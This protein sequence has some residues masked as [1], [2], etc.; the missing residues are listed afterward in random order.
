[1]RTGSDTAARSVDASGPRRRGRPWVALLTALCAAVV[2]AGLVALLGRPTA[3]PLP[4]VPDAG[5]WFSDATLA[6]IAAYRRPLFFVVPVAVV[7]GAVGPLVVVTRPRVRAWL[8]GRGGSPGP[9]AG[10]GRVAL[11]AGAV[12]V[13]VVVVQD[14]L[15]LPWRWWIGYVH[16]GAHGLRTQ[17]LAGWSVDRFVTD[18]T[19]AVGVAVVVALVAALVVW[20]PR[21]WPPVLALAL[22]VLI[23]VVVVGWPLVV[24]PLRFRFQPLPDGPT[25][26]EVVDVAAQAGYDDVRVLVADASR[27]TTRRNAYVSGL[28]ATRRIVLYDTLLDLPDDQIAAVVAHEVAH[29]RHHDLLRG[30]AVGGA[31]TVLAVAAAWLVL[32]S[33]GPGAASRLVS[34][35]STVAV[36]VALALLVR[37]AAAPVTNGLSRQVEAAA[38]ATALVLSDEPAAYAALQRSLVTA[39]LSDP[40]PP[41]WWAWWRASHPSPAERIWRAEQAAAEAGVRID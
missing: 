1:M 9:P 10:A 25:R 29:A 24:E 17:S 41:G 31:V 36:A 28:G 34:D 15:L 14:L 16:A 13:G 26:T 4:P 20:L 32:R 5:R 21:T 12:A 38:D 35:A 40:S 22:T 18:A 39:N 37:A 27:R 11:R 6:D 19:G 3:P 23:G 2:V 33:R 7:V 8:R 30:W